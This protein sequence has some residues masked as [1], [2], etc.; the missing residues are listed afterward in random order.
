[1]I[2]RSPMDEVENLGKGVKYRGYADHVVFLF[3]FQKSPYPPFQK[4]KNLLPLPFRHQNNPITHSLGIKKCPFPDFQLRT[5]SP[6]PLNLYRRTENNG[7][8]KSQNNSL[9]HHFNNLKSPC[10]PFEKKQIIILALLY[11]K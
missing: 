4:P 2:K 9:S 11:Q 6:P 8:I 1:M 3:C 5:R 10:P 7:S